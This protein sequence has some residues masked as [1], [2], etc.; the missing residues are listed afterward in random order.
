MLSPSTQPGHLPASC[1]RRAGRSGGP[2]S[3]SPSRSAPRSSRTRWS[4]T[5]TPESCGRLHLHSPRR[6]KSFHLSAKTPNEELNCRT[7]LKCRTPG[8][9]VHVC[10]VRASLRAGEETPGKS[11]EEQWRAL[12]GRPL[13]VMG[14]GNKTLTNPQPHPHPEDHWSMRSHHDYT[15]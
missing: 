11:L 15:K 5:R 1:G 14:G 10:R 8:Y 6:H 3:C 12:G 7:Q 4:S 13:A 9:S 2:R